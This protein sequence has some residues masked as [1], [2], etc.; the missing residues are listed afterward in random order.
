MAITS[1]KTES[2]FPEPSP[3]LATH[4]S[5]PPGHSFCAGLRRGKTHSYS[6]CAS[7]GGPPIFLFSVQITSAYVMSLRGTAMVPWASLSHELE[8]NERCPFARSESWQEEGP[9]RGGFSKAVCP[10]LPPGLIAA[11]LF[12]CSWHLVAA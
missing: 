4:L 7:P 3:L 12:S 8:S 6:H 10:L 11:L 5:V 2:V 1:A 9:Y